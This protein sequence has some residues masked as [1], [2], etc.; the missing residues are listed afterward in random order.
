VTALEKEFQLAYYGKLGSVWS[1]Q[2]MAVGERDWHYNK[3]VQ[4]KRDEREEQE[5]QTRELR[6]RTH[7]SASSRRLLPR[8]NVRK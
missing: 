3:L 4:T 5:K 8:A 2:H 1:I 6:S 7:G